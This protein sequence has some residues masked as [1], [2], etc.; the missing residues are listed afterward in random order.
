MLI[1]NKISGSYGSKYFIINIIIINI[2]EIIGM[3]GSFN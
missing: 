2:I 1:L 3:Y